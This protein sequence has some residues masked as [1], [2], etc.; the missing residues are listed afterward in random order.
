MKRRPSSLFLLI[1]L[2]TILCIVPVASAQTSSTTGAIT[3]TVTD[4]T[5][6]VIANATVKLSNPNISTTREAKTQADG[7]FTFPLLQ[8]T[9]GYEVTVEQSGFH[10]AV[11]KNITVLVTQVTNT[12]IKLVVG[13]VTEQVEVSGVAEAVQT[14]NA[15]LG[16]TLTSEVVSS[17]PLATRN[18]FELLATDAGVASNLTSPSGTILQGSVAMFVT[19]SR[20]TANNYVLNGVDANNFEFHTLA[21][22]VVPIPNPD[23]VQE[24]RTQTSMYDA[25]TGFSGGGNVNLITRAGTSKF[26]GLAYEYL[27]NDALNAND[28]FLNR[29]GKTKPVMKQNQFGGSFGGPIGKSNKRFFFVNYEGMRQVN[30]VAGFGSGYYPVF[31]ATRD[32]ASLAAAFDV[33]IQNIDPVSLKMLQAKGPYDGYLVPSG[34][35]AQV[36]DKLGLWTFSAPARYTGNQLNSRFDQDFTTW[37]IPNSLAVSYFYSKGLFD[38]TAGANGNAGQPYN[39]PIRNDS[40]S[41]RDTQTIRNNLLNEISVG[42]TWNIRDIYS[43]NPVNPSDIGMTRF[44]E[45]YV[46]SLPAILIDDGTSS[47]GGASASVEQKQHN[48]SA[49]VRD[50]VSWVTGKHNIRIGGEYRAYQFNFQPSPDRGTLEFGSFQDFL[51]GSYYYSAISSGLTNFYFRARDISGFFQDDIRVTNRLTLNLGLR[52]DYF[53]GTTEKFDHMSNFDPSLV[54]PTT[55]LYGGAGYQNAFVLPS[56]LSGFGTPGAS[57]STTNEK[58]KSNFAPR[59][60]FAWDVFGNG[61]MAVRGGAGLY[62]MR[63]AGMQ[64]MQTISNPPFS[65]SAVTSYN[66]NNLPLDNMADPF[67]HLPMPNQYPMWPSSWPTLTGFDADGFPVFN[68]SQFYVSA[69]DRNLKPPYKESWNLAVQYEFLKGWT[70]ELGYAGS[71]GVRLQNA[72]SPNA[73]I[74]HN[75]NNLGPFGIVTNDFAN[76]EARVPFVGI[77]SNGIFYLLDDGSSVYHAG[78]LTVNH[79][80]SK[81]LFFKAAYT[82][83]KS[84]DDAASSTGFEPGIGNPGNPFLNS[85]NRGLSTFDMPHRLVLTYLYALPGPAK[86]WGKQVI[87]GWSVAGLTT[88]QSGL[89]GYVSQSVYGSSLSGVS[90][91]GFIDPSCNLTNGLNASQYP[92]QYLNPACVGTTPYI[93]GT[94]DSTS[95]YYGPGNQTY[96]VDGRLM[97]P[98]NRG[99]WRAPFQQRFDMALIKTFPISKLG[100]ST[101]VQFRADFFKLFNTPIFAGPSATANVPSSFGKITKTIDNTGRQ[102]QFGLRLNF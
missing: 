17:I 57:R 1:C 88:F 2:I 52:W 78:L 58:G 47:F 89:P 15:T 85:L 75:E 4:P 98:A 73:A 25:T 84:I 24:F 56:E 37:G 20:D 23:A 45:N 10:K 46:P 39:Y 63:V 22:G 30:G 7:T 96:T 35:P 68:G 76:R 91:Y 41:I 54:D 32:A 93:S 71:H 11:A 13:A 3:G 80:F 92:I 38:N 18:T 64:S 100:E 90:G 67:A 28:F 31:P 12:T 43:E 99:A 65:T 101:N 42:Y 5:G 27:R 77:G 74:L 95:P 44:N 40:L 19:G 86:G 34:I 79:Q 33:P 26:H 8:P 60:G 36:G 50:M 55:A 51:Q 16:A 94:I 102:I 21:T 9:S 14:S 81:R 69:V 87:G 29:A 97:G 6:A 82:Y 59:I 61:K 48:F 70:L 49:D 83:S 66:P 53:G 62:Y 72:L